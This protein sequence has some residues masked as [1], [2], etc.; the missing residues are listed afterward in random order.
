MLFCISEFFGAP[1]G[2]VTPVSISNTGDDDS[3]EEEESKKESV[4][5]IHLV[6][7]VVARAQAK[8]ERK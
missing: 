8:E 2:D 4:E 5:E 7:P 6:D 1:A 3:E